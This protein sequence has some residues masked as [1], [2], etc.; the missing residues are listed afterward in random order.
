[1]RELVGLPMSLGLLGLVGVLAL[2]ALLE[3]LASI[4]PFLER[5]FHSGTGPNEDTAADLMF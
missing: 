2:L 4:E 3:M 5:L 1:M